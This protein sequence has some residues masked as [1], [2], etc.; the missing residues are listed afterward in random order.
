MPSRQFLDGCGGNRFDLLLHPLRVLLS[1]VTHE[2]RDILWA[3]TQRRDADGK[4]IETVVQVASKLVIRDHFLEIA[5]RRGNEPH[6]DLQRA[7]VAQPFEFPLLQCPQKLWLQ[8]DW[9]VPNFIQEKRALVGKF[10]PA[11]FL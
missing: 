2:E 8:F 11:D 1:E 5:I 10:K 9:D 6:I 7:A 4:N 3:F